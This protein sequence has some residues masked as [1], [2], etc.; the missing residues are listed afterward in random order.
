[1]PVH[2]TFL[3]ESL[4]N[5]GLFFLLIWYRKRKKVDGGVFFLYMILYGAGRFLIEGLRTDS[6]MI[7]NLRASQIL[8]AVLVAV[9]SAVFYIRAKRAA[10]LALENAE[11]G[12]SEYGTILK[13]L[14]E[15]DNGDN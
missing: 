3:Y 15:E 10:K 5:F 8:A 6:L 2:P 4:W 14:N 11:V 13:D 7:G 9:F 1:M 12:S